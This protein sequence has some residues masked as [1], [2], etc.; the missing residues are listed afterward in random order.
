MSVSKMTL[1]GGTK[2]TYRYHSS[3]QDS[4]ASRVLPSA[5]GGQ[6]PL[7]AS[8]KDVVAVVPGRLDDDRH[9]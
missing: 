7:E 3:C 6:P 4:C 2:A 1:A 5:P 9:A 8:L